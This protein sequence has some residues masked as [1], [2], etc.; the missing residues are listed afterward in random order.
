VG[1]QGVRIGRKS[2]KSAGFV[3]PKSQETA[4]HSTTP[5]S[6]GPILMRNS[7]IS[8][9][10]WEEISKDAFFVDAPH[11]KIS[12]GKRAGLC[13]DCGSTDHDDCKE[14]G[15]SCS[16]CQGPHAK[17]RSLDAPDLEVNIVCRSQSQLL[18][19]P[20]FLCSIAGRSTHSLVILG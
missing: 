20:S 2:A 15:M 16:A 19:N 9:K 5:L 13:L 1:V 7:K 11:K 17:N 14:H 10:D 6:P 8:D 12:N 3:L 18:P 4:A